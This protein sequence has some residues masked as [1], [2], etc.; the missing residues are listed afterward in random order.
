MADVKPGDKDATA[1][2]VLKT[3][4]W[5]YA[6]RGSRTDGPYADNLDID[7]I[8]VGGGFSGIYCLHEIR[9]HGLSVALFE[10]GTGYGGTWRWVSSSKSRDKALT[11]QCRARTTSH[12]SAD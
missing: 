10:A 6:K 7:V 12:H 9:K 3:D 11:R 8:I 1:E 5:Q 2:R 4:L